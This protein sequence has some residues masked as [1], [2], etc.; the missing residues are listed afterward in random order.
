MF[1]LGLFR[2]EIYAEMDPMGQKAHQVLG[3]YMVLITIP[4]IVVMMIIL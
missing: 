3:I 2:N 1:F 4:K